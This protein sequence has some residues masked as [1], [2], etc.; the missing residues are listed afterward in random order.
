MNLRK[1]KKHELA[2]KRRE[3]YGN[4]TPMERSVSPMFGTR[5]HDSTGE[6]SAFE[7]GAR[8]LEESK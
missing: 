7:V 4:R 6:G 3:L 2:S 5:T 8:T 1:S